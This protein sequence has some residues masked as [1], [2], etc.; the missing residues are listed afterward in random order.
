MPIDWLVQKE[1]STYATGGI[2]SFMLCYDAWNIL[3]TFGEKILGAFSWIM[4]VF[5][6][7]STFGGLEVHIM[8]RP[9]KI[10]FHSDLWSNC[11]FQPEDT[12]QLQLKYF[13]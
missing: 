2:L 7:L 13:W 1:L 10:H 11:V 12:R 9:G 8:T 4:S 3:Y 6:A 5:F